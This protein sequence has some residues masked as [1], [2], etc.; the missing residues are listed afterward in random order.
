MVLAGIGAFAVAG[1]LKWDAFGGLAPWFFIACFSAFVWLS[2]LSLRKGG[3]QTPIT[4]I[5]MQPSMFSFHGPSSLLHYKADSLRA[6]METIQ[7]F[8]SKALP[9]P[10]AKYEASTD[11]KIPMKESE[12]EELVKKDQ[13]VVAEILK[14]APA[15]IAEIYKTP[16][17][18][19]GLRKP[20]SSL[21]AGDSVE[22]ASPK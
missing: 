13:E 4:H 6:L 12:R 15:L 8:G 21:P 9:V 14:Q 11:K 18:R 5:F 19:V 3:I 17:E 10:S 16:E 7:Q 22:P 1:Y 20:E 2:F